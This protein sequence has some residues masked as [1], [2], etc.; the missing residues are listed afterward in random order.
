MLGAYQNVRSWKMLLSREQ[1]AKMIDHSLLHPSLTTEYI[2]KGCAEAMKYQF[3]AMVVNP[4]HIVITARALR[5]SPVKVCSVISFPFGLS[6]PEV[7]AQE[8][9][10][11]LG[12]GAQEI[13]MVMNFS[14]LRSGHPDIVQS[15]I[16]AVVNE[17]R[18][19][20]KGI[21][22]K[23]ILENCYLSEEQKKQACTLAAQAGADYV[24]TST[25]FGTGGATV[26][27]VRLMRKTV[28]KEL[29]VKAAG[30][31]RTLEQALAM[32]E[33]GANRIGTSA[34]VSIIE[35]LKS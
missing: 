26:E 15:D 28:G 33:A 10:A 12:E 18:R 2:E 27:D 19:F 3:A 32:I 16:K 35:A 24:K 34:G 13:D 5:G 7:K 30:G 29:G 9:K 4:A 20:S 22:V 21:I 1:L 25:G 6:P 17:A 14:A 11:V 31:I 23:V 8:A